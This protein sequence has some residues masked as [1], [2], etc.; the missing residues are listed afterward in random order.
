V[1]ASV[2]AFGDLM[3][4]SSFLGAGTSGIFAADHSKMDEPYWVLG[5]MNDLLDLS[6]SPNIAETGYGLR[7]P[8]LQRNQLPR[9][10]YLCD[11]W[12]RFEFTDGDLTAKIQ[13]MIRDKTVLQQCLI[14]NEDSAERV[15]N[16]S[17]ATGMKIRDLEYLDDLSEFNDGDSGYSRLASPHRYGWIIS[18]TLPES[19]PIPAPVS[20]PERVAERSAEETQDSNGSPALEQA[21]DI[22]DHV[23]QG[24]QIDP[25]IPPRATLDVAVVVSIFVNGVARQWKPNTDFSAAEFPITLPAN[26]T[27]E[28]ATAYKT[29]LTATS[30]EA[31]PDWKDF[32]IPAATTNIGKYLAEVAQTFRPL[33]A[34]WLD[35]RQ[36]DV[37]QQTRTAISSSS[38]LEGLPKDGQSPVN[39]IDFVVRRN[40]EY[41]LSVCAIPVR[42][43]LSVDGE[44]PPIAITCGDIAGHRIVSSASL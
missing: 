18:N 24:S 15:V 35:S 13:W 4:F 17:F 21:T 7:I 23:F 6:N 42:T 10:S 22:K 38:T 9:L 37:P 30:H 25:N 20:A 5:R 34:S 29:V 11:R 43:D 26:T 1:T 2:N 3:Q 36:G 31:K 40:L 14:T 16:L 44:V 32:L 12:P 27:I 33:S 41:I 39:H 8:G 19:P 28:V